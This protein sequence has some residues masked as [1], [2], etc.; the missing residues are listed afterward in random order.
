MNSESSNWFSD[1]LSMLGCVDPS[2]LRISQA[3]DLKNKHTPKKLFKYRKCDGYALN[4]LQN[5]TVWISSPN[6]YNDPFECIQYINFAQ[7]DSMQ[8]DRIVDDAK[9]RLCEKIVIPNDIESRARASSDPIAVIM[10]W[11]LQLD[12]SI[13]VTE[14]QRNQLSALMQDRK[15]N[16]TD[17]LNRAIRSS[18]FISSFSELNDSILMW[19]HYAKDHTGFC[20]EY[21]IG[22]IPLESRHR[23]L[24]YPIQYRLD[25]FDATDH[26]SR[27]FAS[28]PFNNIYG[29][30]AYI[31][32]HEQWSYEKE[33]RLL[34]SHG[35]IKS[36]QNIPF[37][38]AS[39]VYLGCKMTPENR[40][41]IVKICKAKA[42][43]VTD[44]KQSPSLYTLIPSPI[45]AE[46]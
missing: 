13:T 31:R 45:S 32:K 22:S 30:Q 23:R 46:P 37:V 17:E 9:K 5:D 8:S 11:L 41:E 27:S 44:M 29:I 16:I 39:H 28:L 38:R 35:V 18:I 12:K 14:D 7:I 2:D 3:Y 20:I 24:L 10:H 1:F 33:W 15:Q 26:I 40:N 43:P 21:D 4:N 25:L 6:K 42:I 36:E 34:F 19:S